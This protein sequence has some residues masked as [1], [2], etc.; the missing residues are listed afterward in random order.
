MGFFIKISILKTRDALNYVYF[1]H[2]FLFSFSILNL[3]TKNYKLKKVA[4]DSYQVNFSILYYFALLGSL[5]TIFLFNLREA[6][7]VWENGYHVI[8]T[9]EIP[10]KKT[11]LIFLIEI[12]LFVCFIHGIKSKNKIILILSLIYFTSLL[13]T[14]QRLMGLLFIVVCIFVFKPDIFSTKKKLVFF[15]TFFINYNSIS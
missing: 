4:V 3:F 15:Y 6:F 12:L 9:N 8:F 10:F 1:V 14:G 11:F 13:L 7:F 2:L 5:L